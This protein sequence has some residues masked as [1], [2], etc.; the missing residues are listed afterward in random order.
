MEKAMASGAG[1]VALDGR[2]LD[3]PH[4]KQAQRMLHQKSRN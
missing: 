3:F 2:M 4:L 1:T